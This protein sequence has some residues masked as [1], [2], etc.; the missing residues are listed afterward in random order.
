M[1][2]SVVKAFVDSC[3]HFSEGSLDAKH[4]ATLE[5]VTER[6]MPKQYGMP[7]PEVKRAE[8]QPTEEDQER[9]LRGLWHELAQHLRDLHYLTEKA[10]KA[11][12][13]HKHLILDEPVHLQPVLAAVK[14]YL[15]EERDCEELER[16]LPIG[17]SLDLLWLSKHLSTVV[18][19]IGLHTCWDGS[20]LIP[21]KYKIGEKTVFGRALSFR[22]RTLSSTDYTFSDRSLYYTGK[23]N[24]VLNRLFSDGFSRPGKATAQTIPRGFWT[25]LGDIDNL[26]ISYVHNIPEKRDLTMLYQLAPEKG[27]T[28]TPVSALKNKDFKL[29]EANWAEY[30]ETVARGIVKT[31]RQQKNR[32]DE[33][34]DLRLLQ[35]K[36]WQTGYYTGAI[37]GQWEKMSHQALNVFLQDETLTSVVINLRKEERKQ[38]QKAL[39]EEW[40]KK[41]KAAEPGKARKELRKQR[42]EANKRFEADEKEANKK[43]AADF[44]KARRVRSLL[45]PVNRDNQVYAADFKAILQHLGVD[46]RARA[47]QIKLLD[48]AELMD[49]LQSASG[50]DQDAFDE[51]ILREEGVGELYPNNFKKPKRR[52]SFFRKLGGFIV[53]GITKIAK[54]L[55]ETAKKAIDFVLGPVFSFVKKLLRP[56]RAAIH[57]FFQGFKYLAN[58]VFGRPIVTET[59]PATATAP[60]RVFATKFQ[61]DFDAVN[62]VPAGFEDGEPDRHATHLQRMQ[63]DMAYFLDG[64]VWVIKAIGKLS[65]PGGWVWLGW[66]IM[67]SV[68]G[69][70][71]GLA[72]LW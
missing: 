70:V 36:L 55:A 1:A 7:F 38:K 12:H 14:K 23:D 53:G 56:I 49:K 33:C 18:N 48:E 35:I 51:K 31:A 71:P 46:M 11:Y 15:P 54:W 26:V 34:L 40:N 29:M 42:K 16:I 25:A 66:Q 41:I 43:D 20:I 57:R 69:G 9:H 67:K 8:P 65:N 72:A 47:N 2:S 3:H 30:D 4:I 21:N 6:Q 58:F 10:F 45:V 61:L 50:V 32:L 27:V 59:A 5:E 39:K 19:R 64:V 28:Q 24:E 62:F 22:L 63:A 68:I 44:K 52:V 17:Y 60:A 13:K 37:D